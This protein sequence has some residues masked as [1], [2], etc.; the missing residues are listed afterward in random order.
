MTANPGR[1]PAAWGHR[2]S[3]LAALI[4]EQTNT[5]EAKAWA[6][7][8][9]AEERVILLRQLAG[10]SE[11]AAAAAITRR[12]DEIEREAVV[13]QHALPCLL[14]RPDVDGRLDV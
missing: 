4:E 13:L 14:E 12:A 8:N 2:W 9:A 11:P 10:E 7:I 1:L 6:L 3:G 5:V